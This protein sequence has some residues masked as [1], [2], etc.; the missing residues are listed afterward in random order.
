MSRFQ[1]LFDC[2][3]HENVYYI[4]VIDMTKLAKFQ[5]RFQSLLYNHLWLKFFLEYG[6]SIIVTAISAIFFAF[7]INVFI[8]PIIDGSQELVSGGASGASQIISKLIDLFTNNWSNKL[9]KNF[10]YYCIYVLL[11]IPLIVLAFKGIGK[12]F[13]ALT[14]INVAFVF[15]FGWLLGNFKFVE[16]FANYFEKNAG[17]LGRSFF[18]GIGVG[19]SSALAYKI[20]SS[21]GGFDIITYYISNKKST[22]VGKYTFLINAV[23]MVSYGIIT[24]VELNDWTSGFG[25]IFFSFVYLMTCVIVIDLINIRNKK[26]RI[27]IVTQNKDLAKLLLANIP[28]GA[29]VFNGKG[30]YTGDDKYLI[31]I[32]VSTLEVKKVINVAKQ[33]DPKSFINVVSLQ[34]VYGSFHT[35][36]IK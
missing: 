8:K 5:K 33:L 26:T 10:L 1:I 4:C 36:T 3:I 35:K 19:L 7:S 14:L 28:H 32:V 6:F 13:A 12:R 34:Q 9:P 24:S 15:F 23:I 25:A 18:A 17:L 11:N 16:S 27:E 21:A 2:F 29:T 30:V 31:Y 22:A 20:D